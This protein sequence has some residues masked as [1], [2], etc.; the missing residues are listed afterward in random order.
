MGRDEVGLA[1]AEEEGG[2]DG[3]GRAGGFKLAGGCV[4]GAGLAGDYIAVAGLAGERRER[5]VGS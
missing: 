5:G 1:V 4:A 2:R 3:V